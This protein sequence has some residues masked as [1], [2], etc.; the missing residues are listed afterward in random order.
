MTPERAPRDAAAYQALLESLADGVDVDWGALDAAATSNVERRRYSNLRL[1]ARVAELHRT[2]PPDEDSQPQHVEDEE[3]VLE[4]L[5]S[6]GHLV[7]HE[8]IGGG[9]YGDVYRA[10][11][12]QLSR[13]VALK[14][15][16]PDRDGSSERLLA[17]ARILARVRHPHVVTVHGADVRGGRAG[18]WMELVQ[19][20]T[21][22]A[23]LQSHGVMGAG[24]TIVA[25]VDL[26]RALSAVHAAGLVHGDLKA[27]NVM[28]EDKGRL[29][30]MDFGA[31]RVQG[32]D[33]LAVAGTPL[34]LAP[35]VLAGGPAT[36]RSDI[37]SLGVLLFHLLTG[38]Y[39]SAAQDLDELRAA[40][41]DGARVWLRD[42]RPD[43]P[44]TLVRGI[45]RALDADPA[46]R[47]A[48]AGEMERAF[49][50]DEDRPRP[51]VRSRWLA[52]AALFAG[53]VALLV[54]VLPSRTVSPARLTKLA[55]FPFQTVVDNLAQQPLVDGLTQDVVRE[56]QRFTVDVKYAGTGRPGAIAAS[57]SPLDADG[58]VRG[59][60]RKSRDRTA[61]HIAVLRAGGESLWSHEYDEYDT[62]LPS[63]ARKIA[64]DVAAAVGAAPR[65]EA[66]A[67]TKAP[68]YAAFEAYQHGRALAEQREAGALV[69][70]I[71][72]FKRAAALDADYAEPWAGMADSYIALGVSAFGPLPPLEARRLAKASAESAL[73][74]N[75]NLA[76]AHTSLAFAAFFHD[77]DWAGADARFRKAISLNPQYA[78]AHHWYAN[79][80]NAMGRQHEAMDE[81]ER[82]QTLQP[83]S[84][85]I[86]RDIGW[87]LFFQQRYDEA[88][89]HLQAT[90]LMD[91]DYAPAKTLLARALAERGRY[92]E[93]LDQL[94]SAADRMSGS[95]GVNL[96]F[97]AYVQAKSGDLRAAD[98]TMADVERLAATEY[99]PPYY[100]ALVYTVERRT[101]RALDE[102][103]RAYREQD[104]TLVSLR[105]D[106]RFKS[107]RNEP[108]FA[109]LVTRMHFPDPQP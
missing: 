96:S 2:L 41:A 1:V 75:P 73:D 55:V 22:Q 77:W 78:L 17:E 38:A 85:L 51:G 79:Y 49:A 91:P 68:T 81:I 83:L 29:V 105:I 97:V 57:G 108:R 98:A 23:W 3:S 11:D 67:G 65:Q 86:H 58:L 39:P 42:L 54:A 59:S 43:L 19:G 62:A 56:M 21:L 15:L 53:A 16:R 61:V 45:E 103:E 95:R 14:L 27:Q 109:A 32:A 7:I 26:C 101:S 106:P 52:G 104:S 20:Q 69:R 28:R 82:A 107:L 63:L 46:R 60:L 48:T 33:S 13:D 84:V 92:P 8:R 9:A 5:T 47:F 64:R 50:L 25:G 36:P 88:I 71:D 40:H 80:L 102:L 66:A 34:Y 30:L 89:A 6:W 31:G 76:E 18:L 94:R 24:E 37:Y 100:S 90:L 72:Y 70:S 87:H 35:E 4:Q 74:R 93:A 10:S 44:P 12:P 99:I